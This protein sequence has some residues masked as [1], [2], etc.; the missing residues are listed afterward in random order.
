MGMPGR[1][2]ELEEPV[3]PRELE[4]KGGLEAGKSKNSKTKKP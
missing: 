2:P 4:N 1:V 3:L